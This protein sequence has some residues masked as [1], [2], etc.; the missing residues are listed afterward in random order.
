MAKRP[1][2]AEA[3]FEKTLE[4]YKGL[5]DSRISTLLDQKILASRGFLRSSYSAL[6]EFLLKGGKRLRP[7]MTIMAYRAVSPRPESKILGPAVGIEFFHNSSLIHDDIMDEDSERRGMPSMHKKFEEVFSRDFEEKRCERRIFRRS[8]ERFGVSM[9]ILQGNIL[10]ALTGSCFTDSPFDPEKIRKAL[11]V[12]NRAYQAISEG[13]MLDILSELESD[14]SE[15]DCWRTI[16]AKTAYLFGAA[17]EVGAILGGATSAQFETLSQ[18]AVHVGTAFQLQ[19]DLLDVAPGQEGHA[20]GS[21]IRRG[22]HTLLVVKAIKAANQRQRKILRAA[23][24][25][26]EADA[27][28]IEAAAGVLAATG[29][30]DEVRRLARQKLRKGQASLDGGDLSEEGRAFFAGLANSLGQRQI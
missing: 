21:D 30:V 23:L 1:A 16:R 14:F 6:K 15:R 19:D 28:A 20:V 8:S 9:A 10:Y 5:I 18:Y 3:D 22:K 7:A 25:N 24:G 4:K 27:G 11:E 12:V 29:A 26:D 13:Q 17:V 2:P